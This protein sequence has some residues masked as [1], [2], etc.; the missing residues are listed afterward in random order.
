MDACRKYGIKRFHQVSTDEVYG[1]LPLIDLIFY[2]QRQHLFKHLA[3]TRPKTADLLVQHTIEHLAS[4]SQFQDAQTTMDHTTF[5]KNLFL[6]DCKCFERKGLPFMA[7]VKCR[8]W[9][10]V[11]DHCRAID[12]I[13]HKGT[14]VK[15]ITLVDIMKTN[16]ELCKV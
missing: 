4:L 2:L 15:Y 7:M 12:L 10:H 5:L 8:D 13:I 11:E 6:N 3:H 14:M 1:D 9:L 16:L